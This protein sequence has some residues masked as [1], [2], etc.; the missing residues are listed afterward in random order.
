MLLYL[1]PRAQ[2]LCPKILLLF[3]NPILSQYRPHFTDGLG[4]PSTLHDAR[5][6]SSVQVDMDQ[7]AQ[8]LVRSTCSDGYRAGFEEGRRVG[9]KEAS[10]T[11]TTTTPFGSANRLREALKECEQVGNL[12]T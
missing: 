1:L 5:K 6:G 2:H 8:T 11:T 10:T 12:Q 7:V 4:Y 3:P 9:R